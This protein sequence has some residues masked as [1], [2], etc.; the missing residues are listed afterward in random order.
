MDRT[1]DSRTKARFPVVVMWRSVRL[2]SHSILPF[3]AQQKCSKV[4]PQM[5]NSV[6]G[7]PKSCNHK[8]LYSNTVGANNSLQSSWGYLDYKHVHLHSATNKCSMKSK[9]HYVTL[10]APNL[11]HNSSNGDMKW[12]PLSGF[13]LIRVGLEGIVGSKIKY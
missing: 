12:N 13:I 1:L 4:E 6:I 10:H 8:R 7:F 9:G 5:L 11:E 2:T 3:S